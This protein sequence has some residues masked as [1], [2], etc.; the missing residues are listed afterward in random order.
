M[1]MTQSAIKPGFYSG[2]NGPQFF[3]KKIKGSYEELQVD[4][5]GYRIHALSTVAEAREKIRQSMQEIDNNK[6]LP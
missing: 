1:D 3:E 6:N 5:T 2:N 4:N